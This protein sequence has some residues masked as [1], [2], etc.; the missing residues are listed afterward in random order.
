MSELV[1]V[2]GIH[3]MDVSVSI[4]I[5]SSLPAGL[6]CGSATCTS[7]V[8]G[9]TVWLGLVSCVGNRA[10]KMAALTCVHGC[11]DMPCCVLLCCVLSL[12]WCFALRT[13]AVVVFSPQVPGVLSLECRFSFTGRVE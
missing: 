12:Y 13:A 10:L 4:S 2:M 8:L 6:M 3:G 9:V 5:C 11:R 1:K 7:L